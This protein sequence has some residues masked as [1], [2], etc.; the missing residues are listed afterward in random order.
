[1]VWVQARCKVQ[2]RFH[3]PAQPGVRFKEVRG[4]VKGSRKVWEV[5]ERSGAGQVEGS[6]KVPRKVPQQLEDLASQPRY[7][8][9]R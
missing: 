6:R 9:L 5:P 4:Q 1:M 8:P 3:V 2:G 7:K